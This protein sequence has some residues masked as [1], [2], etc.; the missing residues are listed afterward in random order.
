MGTQH[1]IM[2]E[3]NIIVPTVRARGKNVKN[4]AKEQ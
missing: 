3:D 2:M 4:H 1:I